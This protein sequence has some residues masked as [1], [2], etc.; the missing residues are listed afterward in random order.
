[1]M[2]ALSRQTINQVLKQFETQGALKLGYAEIEIADV[3]KLGALADLEIGPL[4]SPD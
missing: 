2:L 4:P 1:M 3:R